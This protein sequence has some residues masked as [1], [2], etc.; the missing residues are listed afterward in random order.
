MKKI[1]S[2]VLAALLL[3]SAVPT[4][5]ATNDYSQGTQ[6]VY[7]ATGNESYTITVPALLAPGGSGTV[8]LEG[9]WADNR[10]ITVTAEPTVTLTNSI[11]A[12]DQKVLNVHF[13]GISEAGSNTASQTFTENV[14]VDPIEA[15]LFGTW[16]G[17]FNY[18]V[19]LT[20]RVTW[21]AYGDMLA[22]AIPTSD[23][24]SDELASSGIHF[25]Y[26][27]AYEPLVVPSSETEYADDYV[28]VTYFFSEQ[29]HYD[30]GLWNPS[31]QVYSTCPAFRVEDTEYDILAH[32][33][34]YVSSQ[35]FFDLLAAE[36]MFP[37]GIS[38]NKNKWID[39]G[40]NVANRAA[41]APMNYDIEPG[42]ECWSNYDI[43]TQGTFAENPGEIAF[44]KN[45]PVF[46][47]YR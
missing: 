2:F 42:D 26:Y 38:W 12:E 17:K 21:Y 13:D 3:V 30:P 40:Y 47:G 31:H 29:A 39:V 41:F 6:V 18:N 1:I 46:I 11:K 5:L 14:S 37:E 7:E 23:E 25:P 32:G 16:N 28:L 15:A 45:E 44:A 34:V 22:P 10:I 19:A 4:A 24:Y 33:Y 27:I 8:T 20:D 35:E 36:G 43:I 9:T